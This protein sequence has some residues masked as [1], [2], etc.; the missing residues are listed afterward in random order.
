MRKED[1]DLYCNVEPGWPLH[2]MAKRYWL[3]FLRS[4]TLQ[5]AGAPVK[6]ELLGEH[7][8]AFRAGNGRVGLLDEQCSHRGISLSLARNEGNALTCIFHGWTY[9]A[10]GTC[11]RT[12]TEADPSF[13]Q[14][15]KVRAFPVR[16]AGGACWVYLGPGDPPRFPD[17]DF[18]YVAESYRR[19]RV[20]Y[21]ESNWTQNFEI[22]LDSS[23]IAVLHRNLVTSGV[24]LSL[25][26]AAGIDAPKLEVHNTPYGFQSFSRRDRP[27]GTTYLRVTEYLAPFTCLIG[28]S[29][30]EESK[31][32]MYVPINNRRSAFWF[33]YW[34]TSHDQ[35]WWREQY[36]RMGVVDRF[37][38]NDDDLLGWQVRRNQPAFGQDRDLMKTQSWSGLNSLQAEDCVV[39][40][41]MPMIY[42]TREQ[43]G[44][45]D[46]VIAAMRR[47]LLGHL[48]TFQE[49][50]L[51]YGLGPGG[52]G[53]GIAY[54]SLRA[55]SEVIPS[56]TDM[57]DY[58]NR[59]LRDARTAEQQSRDAKVL[60]KMPV[61]A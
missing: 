25:G 32:L 44:K 4:E 40:E 19:A 16:E 50:G 36:T 23:H 49:T 31:V 1:N 26:A 27:D 41:S 45:S 38:G 7:Y 21:T 42:R 22:L 54:R 18:N 60:S 5:T 61:E 46:L 14:R 28:S 11:I 39:A 56:N 2:D 59:V 6:V 8:V 35:A 12:P 47:E 20:G 13:P 15:V 34:D 33:F 17:F 57:F 48:K 43:L 24:N 10:S 55:T 53:S 3:P 30:E 52:N 37:F 9:D 51:A 58:H 29:T